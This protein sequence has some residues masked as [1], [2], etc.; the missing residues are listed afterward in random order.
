MYKF[1]PILLFAYGLAITT[2]EIYD[3]SYALIIGIDKYEFFT[4]LNYPVDDA[5]VLGNLLIN[6]FDFPKENVKVLINE[7]ADK[8]SIFK[9]LS[10]INRKAKKNDRILIFFA[11]H[12]ETLDLDNG[13]ELG[14]LLP[15]DGHVNDLQLSSISITDMMN[16][17][18]MSKAKHMLFL[19]DA[20]MGGLG[21]FHH[22]E[23]D[24]KEIN[25]NII[26][27]NSRQII[28]GGGRT[29]VVI[30]NAEWGHSV[31]T[32]SLIL[33]LQGKADY[34]KD[35]IIIADELGHYIQ[36]NVNIDSEGL[37]I[38][39]IGRLKNSHDGEFIFIKNENNDAVWID[40][41]LELELEK[42]EK[43]NKYVVIS[44][45]LDSVMQSPSY[46]SSL[47]SLSKKELISLLKLSNEQNKIISPTS[48]TELSSRI[49]DNFY[50]ESFAVIIGINK[51][52]KSKPLKYAVNDAIE[53]KNML[54]NKFGF[55]DK[56]IRLLID[57]KATYSSIREALYEVGE[58]ARANDRILIYFAGHGTHITTASGMDIGYLI[59]Y[60]GNIDKPLLGGIPMDDFFRMCQFSK[61]KHMLFLMDACYSGLMAES[62]RGLDKSQDN[63][64][65]ISTVSNISARQIITAGNGEQEVWE[66][67]EW[68]H[69]AFTYNLVK[70]LND[71]KADAYKDGYITA[72][73][74]GENLKKTVA[75][76]TQGRQT[77]QSERIKASKGGEFIFFQ[78]P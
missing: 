22:R 40:I 35:D 50:D 56:N 66:S 59:P 15:V 3:D 36:S 69:S 31:F 38:P 17:A 18:L 19:F 76:E 72:T 78:N 16:L 41:K 6:S 44:E 24:K 1:L 52:T 71:W 30:E 28:V 74:L 21:I 57:S 68:Q 46:D 73:E 63:E 58:Q 23:A 43:Q 45:N 51:Y 67:D 29:D 49:G 25:Q 42:K 75:D 27:N 48:N 65:Y 7:K 14:Y 8:Q 4:N 55:D 32:K 60:E 12:G 34:N 9:E 33:G 5:I 26:N 77:P 62:S 47:L 54:I 11:G 10:M 13:A 53:I 37:Q 20:A 39:N 61:S 64:G 2:D 70:A